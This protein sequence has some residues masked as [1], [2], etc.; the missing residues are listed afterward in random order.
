MHELSVC[1]ALMQQVETIAARHGAN[2]V[3]SISLKI[4]PLSGIEPALLENAFPLAA[5]G[6]VAADA[7]LLIEHSDIVVR[8]TACGECSVVAAN[9]LLCASCGDFRT[10][11]ESGDEMLLASLE[12]DGVQPGRDEARAAAR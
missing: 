8:C 3:T 5:T 12:L 2:R 9:R 11:L 7:Q 6:T 1:L 4:G 10:N